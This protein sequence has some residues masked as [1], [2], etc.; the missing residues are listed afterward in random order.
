MLESE[1]SN[2][3]A[4]IRGAFLRGESALAVIYA[5]DL[6]TNLDRDLDVRRIWAAGRIRD[7]Q[8]KMAQKDIR[9]R[10]V[11]HIK[12]KRREFERTTQE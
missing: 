10:S 11:A 9:N 8:V 4:A 3:F 2:H 7:D 12:R 1:L 5:R 6:V